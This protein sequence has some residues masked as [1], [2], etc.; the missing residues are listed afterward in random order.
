MVFIVTNYDKYDGHSEPLW[1]FKSYEEA[2][3]KRLELCSKYRDTFVLTGLNFN[4]PNKEAF[5]SE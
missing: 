5:Y 3:K 2:E 4:E 1:V